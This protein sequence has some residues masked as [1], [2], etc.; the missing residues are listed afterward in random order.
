MPRSYPAEFRCRV[1]DLVAFGQKAAE[2]AESIRC[3]M[4][5]RLSGFEGGLVAGEGVA[6]SSPVPR[7]PSW[8]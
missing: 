6:R 2:W 1:L 8:P 7:P 4:N 5:A 3:V